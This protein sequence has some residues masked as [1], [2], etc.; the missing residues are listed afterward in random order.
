MEETEETFVSRKAVPDRRTFLFCKQFDRI[1]CE[2][3]G[4]A[5][6]LSMFS[7]GSFIMMSM[8]D[9]GKSGH[10]RP[11]GNVNELNS[12][13]HTQTH[14]IVKELARIIGILTITV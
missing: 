9:G 7:P 4:G 1:C 14:K 8:K 11:G 5:T 2:I 10:T 3:T 12:R 13:T 6:T